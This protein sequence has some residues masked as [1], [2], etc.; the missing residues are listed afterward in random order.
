MT[1]SGDPKEN[2]QAKRINNTIK[3]EMFKGLRFTHIN[4]VKEELVRAIDFYNNERPHMSID[5]MTP[6][7]A[8][9]CSEEIEK[10][11]KSYRLIAIKSKLQDGVITENSLPLLNNQ[12]MLL[13]Q[14]SPVNP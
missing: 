11:W 7:E 13:N 12:G 9:T 2:A 5:M 3:N 8:A 10:R 14:A 6:S 4:Q 1:E